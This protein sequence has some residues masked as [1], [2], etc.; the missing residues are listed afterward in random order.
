MGIISLVRSTWT[1]SY[2]AL[3]ISVL[4]LIGTAIKGIPTKNRKANA[5]L[6]ILNNQLSEL[7]LTILALDIA[8]YLWLSITGT[9][10]IGVSGLVRFFNYINVI[11]AMGLLFLLKRSY[12]T[13]HAVEE[14]LRN[15]SKEKKVLTELPGFDSPRFW[16]QILSPIHAPQNCL[17][18]ENIYYWTPN[19]Q[20]RVMSDDGWE[21][22]LEMALD[23]YRPKT[24][25]G[26]DNRPVFVYIHG[27]G[28]TSGNKLQTG[29]LLTELISR[30]WVVVS[31]GYRV[32]SKSPYPV[33][34]IDCKRALRWIKDEINI[35]GGDPTNI[36]VGGDSS[37]GHLAALLALTPNRPEYQPGFE[38]VDT[39]IQGC[40][41]QSG[42]LDLPDLK[43]YSHHDG[44]TRFIKEVARREGS[45]E[46]EDNL[47]FLTEHSPL[48]NV[49]Q[50]NVPFM[51]IHGDL[52]NMTPVQ[53]A[54]DFVQE[55][56][57]KSKA[58]IDYLEIPGGH[59]CFHVFPS[60]RTWYTVIATAEWLE[61]NF[62]HNKDMAKPSVAGKNQ[63]QD[64][65][66]W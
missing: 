62:D 28:W 26:G 20:G 53:S 25:E 51:I 18:H 17:I 57:S 37:G 9:A 12:D 43:N 16:R 50:A 31:V 41:P 1:W 35:Y 42:S 34:L 55:F 58:S 40:V 36:I 66:E 39:T 30:Q 54:R 11:S 49:Q 19:E 10:Q 52:D 56:K 46:S 21:T 29:P 14:F 22:A 47:R 7:P 15:L 4:L 3:S 60:P 63:G 24:I 2:A 8:F 48:H 6:S 5:I 27:G 59:H 64:L 44:R 65:V 32:T 33:Q 23:I 45:A 13:K 38:H 61:A